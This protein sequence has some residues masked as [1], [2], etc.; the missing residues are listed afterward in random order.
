MK[1][2]STFE[3]TWFVIQL[4]VHAPVQ[5][6]ST[7]TEFRRIMTE[8]LQYGGGFQ[9]LVSLFKLKQQLLLFLDIS[10][11]EDFRSNS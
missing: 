10:K 3:S 5:H 1:A 7:Y 6:H 4:L 9:S 8:A 11:C 2:G